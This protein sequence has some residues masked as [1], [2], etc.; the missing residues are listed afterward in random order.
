MNTPS[1]EEEEIIKKVI[2]IESQCER[3][4]FIK[5]V[6]S[7]NQ[8]LFRRVTE[9]HTTHKAETGFL[10]GKFSDD[11]IIP[12]ASGMT[13]DVGSMIGRYKLLEKIG[14]GGFGVVWAAEQKEP[15]RRRVA[16][17]IIKLGMD[18]NQ[19]IARFESERQAL[20]LMDHPNIAMVLDA[21]ATDTGRPFFVMELV[22]GIL[23]TEYCDQ[24]NLSI[25][26]RLDLFIKVCQAI[27]HA[28]QKG[29]I[30][31]DIKPS[32]IMVTLH[33]GVPVPKVIDFGV[34]KATQQ[35]LT[36]KTIYTQYNQFIG[37]PTYMSPEQAEMSG[38]DI[39]TR[40]D[41]YSLGVLLY[42]LLTSS[43]P[44]DSAE[45]M[46]SG[47]D[48]M[49]KIIRERDPMLPSTR[50]SQTLLAAD[51][52]LL[53]SNLPRT[54]Q[55]RTDSHRLL[56]E[57]KGDL[58][59][60]V[61][62]CLEKDRARRYETANGIAAD[63]KRHLKHEPVTAA[64]P[65]RSY[66]FLKLYR[67]NRAAMHAGAAVV[68]ILVLTA[69]V[70]TL[71]AIRANVAER[72]AARAFEQEAEM[73][74]KAESAVEV[75][76]RHAYSADMNLVQGA[77]ENDNLDRARI[78]LDH[79]RP[80]P[81]QPDIRGWEWRYL[82]QQSQS[83]ESETLF[84]SDVRIQELAISPDGKWLAAAAGNSL[85]AIGKVSIW[86]LPNRRKLAEFDRR[87][88]VDLAISPV[89]PILAF[90]DK[91]DSS[92]QGDSY[93]I[94]LWNID[95]QRF[96]R[97][98]P[99]RFPCSDLNISADGQVLMSVTIHSFILWEIATGKKIREYETVYSRRQ[100]G[101]KIAVSADLGV[102][103]F[104]GRRTSR[105]REIDL[106]S[107]QETQWASVASD[108]A[109][110][111]M[112][113]SPDGTTL[114]TGDGYSASTIRIWDT[115]TRREI[116]RL[117]G[118]RT[119]ISS[120]VFWPDGR[121]LASASGD[122]TIRLWDLQ[123]LKPNRVLRG[124]AEHVRDIVL[125]PD[126]FTL[127]SAGRDGSV[128]FWD[129]SEAHETSGLV[130]ER[131][132]T[133]WA[134]PRETHWAF[135]PDSKSIHVI[136]RSAGQIH[137]WSGESYRDR[138]IIIQHDDL[139]GVP[140]HTVLTSRPE[141]FSETGKLM[142][143]G[144]DDGQI[145]VWDIPQGRI[146]AKL[147][148]SNNR[149]IPLGFTLDNSLW[150]GV[151]ERSELQEWDLTSE[152][153]RK[154]V[155]VPAFMQYVESGNRRTLTDR[156]YF[157]V[158]PSG[159]GQLIDLETGESTYP[160]YPS[161]VFSSVFSPDGETLA[162]THSPGVLAIRK[163]RP[164]LHGPEPSEIRLRGIMGAFYSIAFSP[165]GKRVAASSENDEAI[166]LWDTTG[167][168]ELLTLTGD[169]GSFSG[170]AFS[171][172]GNILGAISL[173]GIIHLWPAP[174]WEEIAAFEAEEARRE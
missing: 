153:M 101:H 157:T 48:E 72:K 171:P 103:Y 10:P 7:E 40:S 8:A 43:P 124:H 81:G 129:T 154:A 143:I 45:L 38:L 139:K 122:Q 141:V 6:C 11:V 156:Y 86:D 140:G 17:K 97:D 115:Q 68:V 61:M 174:S 76:R 12:D 146:M 160:Q 59:L 60:I 148:V 152:S 98:L 27:Q 106:K 39:D 42:E 67:R 123:E 119:Y 93:R 158:K 172:D 33:D 83:Q 18:T 74:K 168:Q 29:I 77:L 133:G 82:W 14:E 110:N 109:V 58:D 19:V 70:S 13:E 117:E 56:N 104:L 150:V 73:R 116:G 125:S 50:L 92:E 136:D 35:E 80:S 47:W 31:R 138:Q 112:A 36:E 26:A 145:E 24:E 65:T 126:G 135:A 15:I 113:L 54:E 127:I 62:K 151:A 159:G 69:I 111:A 121:T 53:K 44:F 89:D 144:S 71:L 32:N 51:M 147:A 163:T 132:E 84:N 88:Q 46:K 102:A 28:H 167:Y 1:N 16:L 173:K 34:A 91:A 78:L 4:E 9:L 107:G 64:A 57:L 162:V 120:L 118:H 130:Q 169:G 131:T 63:L 134:N 79:H 75:T 170:A 114:A 87:G 137:R 128:K 22:K 142:T 25:Q 3:D 90:T 94:R 5:R 20:A 105:I 30:H 37:T 23:M 49:R 96:I 95:T 85:G 52:S 166:R 164:L 108:E 66:R 99:L 41:I 149:V 21:G 165:D 161:R 55:V 155:P 100:G 2:K